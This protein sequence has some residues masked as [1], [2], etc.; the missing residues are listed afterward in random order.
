MRSS[1]CRPP[2]PTPL[3][4]FMLVDDA[5]SLEDY[6]ARFEYTIPLLQ[7]RRG[8]RAGV[9]TRWWRMRRATGCAISRCATAPSS[10]PGGGLTMEQ[11]LEAELRGLARGERDFGV[12][13]RVINCSLR[14]YAPTIS[15]DDR[16]AVGGLPRPRRGGVRPGGRRGGPAARRAPG[17]VR[18]RGRRLPR[19]HGPRRARPRAPSRSPRRCT[20]ATRDRIG[21][22]T[23]LYED[24]GAAGLRSRPPDPASR[25]T[26]PATCRPARWPGPR[27]IRCASYFDAGLAVTLCTDG[28][29]MSGVSLTDEYWLAHTEL[30]FTRAGD[31]PHDPRP[32]SST[33]SCPGPSGRRCWP[34]ARSWRRC[35]GGAL[36][37]S[38]R[39]RGASLTLRPSLAHREH[40]CD[41]GIVVAGGAARGLVAFA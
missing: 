31:R 11:A 6:L 20:A 23:R 29:L 33:R 12:V 37:L 17:G 24:P 32:A 19:H 2:I 27:T 38:A 5:G 4:R 14:H 41:R 18:P 22:G 7:T 3:R 40:A 8:D 9:A 21:H 35:A 26:S 34:G 15:V 39:A 16:A 36:A 30:G 1:P 10:A 25:S 13:T 28:W